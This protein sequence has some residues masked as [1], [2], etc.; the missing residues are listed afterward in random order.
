MT[1]ESCRFYEATHESYG[2]CHRYPPVLDPRSAE[3]KDCDR[4]VLATVMADDWC[5]EFQ[6]EESDPE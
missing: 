6:P 2:W 3:P 5:G 4:F 1:C